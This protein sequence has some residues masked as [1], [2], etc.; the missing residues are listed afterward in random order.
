MV[1]IQYVKEKNLLLQLGRVVTG[2][3]TVLQGRL[4]VTC[5]RALSPTL[6]RSKNFSCDLLK[7]GHGVIRIQKGLDR[8]EQLG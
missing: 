6:F 1:Y 8:L 2:R 7:P 3:R 4:S 5:H